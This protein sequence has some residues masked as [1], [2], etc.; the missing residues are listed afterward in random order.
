M[1]RVV[2]DGATM[3]IN[4][5]RAWTVRIPLKLVIFDLENTLVWNEFLPELADLVGKTSEV[6]EITRQG[7]DGHIDWEEGFRRRARLLAGIRQSDVLRLA[8][9]LRP[10]PG[11][12]EIVRRL[13][14]AGAR[15]VLVTGGPR[16]VAESAMALFDTDIAFANEFVYD[17]GVFTGDV[18]VRVSPR[19][20]GEIVRELARK[21][22]VAR[23]EILA[24][25]DGRM[26]LPLLAEAGTRLGINTNGKL[27]GHV[28]LETTDYAEA[29]RWL[30]AS[31][32]LPRST[33]FDPTVQGNR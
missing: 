30:E 12:V 9:A 32:W 17:S 13:R 10:V 21:W 16:E 29:E 14:E 20:K 7:I 28:H 23:D 31:G 27:G 2:A 5:G 6:M 33:G 22:A 18:V 8:R 15:I 25:G 3:A 24:F 1:A 19:L 4:R 26:D 11:A